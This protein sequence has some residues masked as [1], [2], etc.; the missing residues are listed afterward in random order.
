MP[1]NDRIQIIVHRPT[2]DHILKLSVSGKVCVMRAF[3]YPYFF[4]I[5][6]ST[7]E[8]LAVLV[9]LAANYTPAELVGLCPNM[10][11]SSHFRQFDAMAADKPLHVHMRWAGSELCH[12]SIFVSSRHASLAAMVR[13]EAWR[14]ETKID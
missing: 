6:E 11:Q 9:A 2:V 14:L 7:L 10:G 12:Q 13:D 3:L 8:E 5:G 4:F 1:H